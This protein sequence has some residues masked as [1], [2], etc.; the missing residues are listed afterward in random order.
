[1]HAT[2]GV[3][4][5]APDDAVESR[6]GSPLGLTLAGEFDL[7]KERRENE[8]VGTRVYVGDV[9]VESLRDSVL[10]GDAMKMGLEGDAAD[11]GIDAPEP[12]EA[13]Y[14]DEYCR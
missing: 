10:D 6:E 9:S 13:R 5:S 8:T 3:E 11:V 1:M 14:L 7:V 2:D 12:R 4:G